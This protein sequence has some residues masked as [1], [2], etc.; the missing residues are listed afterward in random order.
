MGRI[1]N[2][3]SLLALPLV[4]IMTV[5]H[6]IPSS[7][8]QNPGCYGQPRCE[9]WT[10][11]GVTATNQCAVLYCSGA[12]QSAACKNQD[13][14]AIPAS[15]GTN[16]FWRIELTCAANSRRADGEYWCASTGIDQDVTIFEGSGGCSI[17]PPPSPTPGP[18][19][20]PECVTP[21]GTP[22]V[23]DDNCC[24]WQ[25]CGYEILA[26][27]RVCKYGLIAEDD[28]YDAGFFLN[29]LSDQCQET[30][31]SQ[32]QCTNHGWYWNFLGHS[33]QDAPWYCDQQPYMCGSGSTW[34][35]D[36]CQCT[37]ENTQS[38]VLIDVSGNGFALTSNIA[39]VFF[40]LDADGQPELISWT[41]SSSDDAFLVI[42]R[43]RNGFIDN[44]RELFGDVSPQPP[45]SKPNGFLAL[46]EYDVPVN[47]GNGD[48]VIDKNDRAFQ[49]LK[50]WQDTNHNGISESSELRTL[51]SMAVDSIN[52]KYKESK[53]TDEYGNQFRYR[54]KVDDAQ[55]SH[56]GRWAW[57]VFLLRD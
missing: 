10:R 30:P 9:T 11:P 43:N 31:S 15:C 33:C 14:K 54:A 7:Q 5:I 50:L 38:P 8:A 55:H 17:G 57:D 19:P 20:E 47:G 24:W 22:C 26:G 35:F 40:D 34:D 3:I 16:S 21:I 49:S 51:E 4:V 56:L 1:L 36:L 23:N 53:R 28:C 39:G 29:F 48:G 25:K 13:C 41:S 2:T 42:D 44:G 6:S 52:L 27:E 45:A 18:S 12:S 32:D 37:N 46:A